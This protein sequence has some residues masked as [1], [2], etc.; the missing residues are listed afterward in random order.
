M[1]LPVL[2]FI[3]GSAGKW[4]LHR[5]IRNYHKGRSW[6]QH[7]CYLLGSVGQESRHS[8]AEVFASGF[9][10][11]LSSRHQP[12]SESRLNTWLEMDLLSSS[13]VCCQPFLVGSW[14]GGPP[15][16]AGCRPEAA[17]APHRWGFSEGQ[18]TTHGESLQRA[19]ANKM[20]VRIL[21]NQFTKWNHCCH[22]S[23]VP[24]TLKI[25][26]WC[27]H[28]LQWGWAGITGAILESVHTDGICSVKFWFHQS[29]S[30]F[31]VVVSTLTQLRD[32]QRV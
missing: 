29:C 11:K 25:S 7:M 28:E 21:C 24:P 23:L 27:G 1:C 15:F 17:S 20:E 26:G 9:L 13:Y 32:S 3:W 30:F 12:G 14:T 5:S 2:A 8:L 6:N 31:W 18:I 4:V 10:V 22:M 19:S 16:L